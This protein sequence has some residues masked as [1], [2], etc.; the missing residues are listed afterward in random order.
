MTFNLH[1]VSEQKFLKVLYGYY[2]MFNLACTEGKNNSLSIT[3]CET[4]LTNCLAGMV[5]TQYY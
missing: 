5:G 3:V 2:S 1:Q 4:F